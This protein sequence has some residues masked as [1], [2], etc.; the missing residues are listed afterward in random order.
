MIE[1]NKNVFC[2]YLTFK[3]FWY[4]VPNAKKISFCM[5]TQYFNGQI[6]FAWP[7]VYFNGQNYICMGN[8]NISMGK[9]IFARA[10][11]IFQWAKL[12]LLGKNYISMV[13]FIF[14]WAK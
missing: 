13:K 3:S 14:V 6:I 4:G 10:I 5:L 2:L 11:L 12:C 7:I 1:I 8:S 9:T